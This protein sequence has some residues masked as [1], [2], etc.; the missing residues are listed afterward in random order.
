MRSPL[1]FATLAQM[2][3]GG[4]CATVNWNTAFLRLALK[5]ATW[6]SARM[7]A[8]SWLAPRAPAALKMR[9]EA[10]RHRH[11]PLALMA[12]RIYK[13]NPAADQIWQSQAQL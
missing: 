4:S 1:A 8:A 11:L 13:P 12:A 9:R 10:G 5:A 3:V 6:R 7:P 2:P